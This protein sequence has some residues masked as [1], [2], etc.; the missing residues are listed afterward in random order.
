MCVFASAGVGYSTPHTSARLPLTTTKDSGKQVSQ[1]RAFPVV[2]K[3]GSGL[4][5]P[6]FSCPSIALSH[7]H[8]HI[9]EHSWRFDLSAT[10]SLSLAHILVLSGGRKRDRAGR[11]LSPSATYE[12]RGASSAVPFTSA[13]IKPSLFCFCCPFSSTSAWQPNLC[14]ASVSAHF[15]LMCA[16]LF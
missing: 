15:E 8:T 4:Q 16:W 13:V 7:A 5:R 11:C 6:L 12:L 3:P 2:L 9:H 10:F 1:I 14:V